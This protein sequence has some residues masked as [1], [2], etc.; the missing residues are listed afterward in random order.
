LFDR[1]LL[2]Y[3]LAS[4]SSKITFSLQKDHTSIV[5]ESDQTC[6]DQE[7]VNLNR[8]YVIWDRILFTG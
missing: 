1:H 8:S 2:L 6:R 3:V 7:G 5:S 4:T